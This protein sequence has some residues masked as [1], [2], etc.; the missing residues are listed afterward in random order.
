[1]T[2]KKNKNPKS[3]VSLHKNDGHDFDWENAKILDKEPTHSKRLISEMIYINCTTNT[4]NKKE[5]SKSLSKIYN[6][7]FKIFSDSS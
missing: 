1:M 4:L 3:V 6:P 7:I 2:I 5:D